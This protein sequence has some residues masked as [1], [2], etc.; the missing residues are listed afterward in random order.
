MCQYCNGIDA[1]PS[2][3]HHGR[4]DRVDLALSTLKSFPGPVCAP[5]AVGGS[6]AR[7]GQEQTFLKFSR[8][9]VG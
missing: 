4:P 3:A 8:L 7:S 6:Q 5:V 9:T 1:D 2:T